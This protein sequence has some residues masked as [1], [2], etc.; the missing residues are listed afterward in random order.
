MLNDAD[1][2]DLTA[3]MAQDSPDAAPPAEAVGDRLERLSALAE[4]L[5]RAQIALY[6]TDK[7]MEAAE[8]AERRLREVDIPELMKEC[9]MRYFEL[10]N[11]V[12]ISVEPA[13]KCS[14]SEE[15]RADAHAWLREHNLGGIIKTVVAASFGKGEEQQ[16]TA[17]V[18]ALRDLGIQAQAVESVHWQTLAATIR[19]ERANG[20]HVPAEIFGL[21]EYETTKLEFPPGIEKPKKPRP[22]K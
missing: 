1:N 15:R 14:I 5:R 13:L 8:R 6:E 10:R 19:E 18:A 16:A 4:Q 11:G 7:L 12:S 2:D 20:R 9:G 22:K 17:T 3:A 21:F